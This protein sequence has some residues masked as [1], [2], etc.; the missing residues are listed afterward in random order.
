MQKQFDYISHRDAIKM[1]DMNRNLFAKVIAPNVSIA[2]IGAK[3]FYR[4]NQL[5]KLIKLNEVIT[6]K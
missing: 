3:K 2:M 4:I 1:L 6:I 5:N